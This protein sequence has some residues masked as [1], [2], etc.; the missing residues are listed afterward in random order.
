MVVLSEAPEKEAAGLSTPST[1]VRC[2]A[3]AA[4]QFSVW[5]FAPRTVRLL[6]LVDPSR[7]ESDLVRGLFRA[8]HDGCFG[9]ETSS[10]TNAVRAAGHAAHYVLQHHNRDALSYDQVTAA[11]AVAAVRGSMAYV[12]LVG[13]AAVFAWR[14]GRLT[15][16][17][18]QARLGRPLG[19]EQELRFTLWSTPLRPGDRLVLVC[20]ATWRQDVVDTI[21]DILST[22]PTD[23]AERRL[24]EALGGVRVLVDD[25]STPARPVA[26][27]RSRPTPPE[28]RV[29]WKRWLAP[30]LPLA[31]LITGAVATLNPTGQPHHL[32]L[33]LQA[34]S[35]LAQAQNTADQTAAHGF[36]ASALDAARRAAALAPSQHGAVVDQVARALQHIDRV[37]PIQ[38]GLAVHLGPTGSNVVDLAVS[39]DRLYTLDVVEGAV[40]RFDALDVEQWPTPETLLARKGAAVGSRFLDTPVAIQYVPGTAQGAGALTI[41]DRARTIAQLMPDGALSSRSLPGSASWQRLGALGADADGNLYVFDSGAQRLLEYPRASQRLIAP[42]R[43]LLDATS[44]SQVTFD[45]VAEVLPLRDIYVRLED[46]SVR[47][48]GR[49]GADLGFDVRPPDGRLGRIAALAPDRTGGLYLAD[50]TYGRIVHAT[51]DGVFVRQLRDP[52]LA[53]VRGLQ[54]RLDGRRIYG[55]VAAGVLAFDVPDFVDT[56]AD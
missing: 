47:R 54:T 16:Q 30:L 27:H 26:A 14:G 5:P 18:T 55:L 24:S 23:V 50:P 1:T 45:R 38:T 11:A 37:Y 9:S 33:R 51:A 44:Y 2:T 52:A 41:V 31:L 3:V 56:A 15:G 32:A 28:R 48:V 6:L 40:R 17:Y 20:G 39:E 21:R 7:V 8:M 43:P 34:E 22:S 19:A 46:G 13:E 12:A 10:Q 29:G 53:G 4:R 49:D 35:L 25:G 36:A 42:P